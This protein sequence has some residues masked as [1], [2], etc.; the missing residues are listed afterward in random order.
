MSATTIADS[1]AAATRNLVCSR[2]SASAAE[3]VLVAIT[4]PGKCFSGAAEPS[5]SAPS[6]GLSRRSACAPP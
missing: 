5:R 6:I 3:T 4:T 2:Q 1:A